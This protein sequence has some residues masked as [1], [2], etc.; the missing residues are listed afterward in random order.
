MNNLGNL[1]Y[2]IVCICT[3]VIGKAIHG[4]TFWAVI[5]FFFTP[6]AWVKWLVCHEV[7]LSIIK[8]A[9]ASFLQ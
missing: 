7:S 5:D 4:S 1:I 8:G 3:A 9:F 2:L 6:L